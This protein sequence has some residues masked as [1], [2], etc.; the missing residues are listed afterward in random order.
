ML[1][2]SRG[3]L[4]AL[5]IGLAVWFAA[6]RCGCAPSPRWLLRAGRR[7]SRAVGVRAGRPDRRPRAAV[8]P[9]RRG[10]RARRAAAAA[11]R[12]ARGAPGSR[13]ASPRRS[14][15]PTRAC[16]ARRPRP[17]RPARARAR[18]DPDR[19]RRLTGRD[20]RP[21][22]RRLDQ[23][24]RPARP[25]PR[26]HAGPPRRDVLG[27]RAVLARGAEGAPEEHGRRHRRRLLRDDPHPLPH[28]RRHDRPPRARL[29]RADALRPRL[30]RRRPDAAGR[31]RVG[32]DR[33][34]DARDAPQ[35]PRTAVRRRARRRCGRWPTG[36]VVFGVHSA[37][38]WTWFVP[39]NV[40]PALLLA[41][42]VAGRGPLRARLAPEP[43]PVEETVVEETPRRLAPLRTGAGGG[44]PRL[45]GD[46]DRARRLV[47][48]LPARERREPRRHRARAGR[49][50]RL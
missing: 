27:A 5:A 22:Q 33:R 36:V 45:A 24:H 19:A 50:R 3:S 9:H 25:D 6:V 20:R 16:A 21:D 11:R 28:Q 17:A 32:A 48:G 15:R 40:V 39:G 18:R 14:T 12:A 10:P 34:A 23:A 26:Q 2:Y 46:R 31:A 43:A 8:R 1:S 41:G 4:F 44:R 38:D 13:S 37:I 30:G 29:L 47:G 35:R 42:W 7:A 49:P